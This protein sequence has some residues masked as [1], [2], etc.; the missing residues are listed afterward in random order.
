[1][2][3]EEWKRKFKDFLRPYINN[4]P[5]IRE[6]EEL[7]ESYAEYSYLETG[8]TQSPIFSAEETVYALKSFDMA[9]KS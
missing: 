1:M 9:N 5:T 8:D 7:L 3:K 4:A 6:L 2:N